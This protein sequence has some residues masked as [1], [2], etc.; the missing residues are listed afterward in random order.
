MPVAPVLGRW[1]P[2][3]DKFETSLVYRITSRPDWTSD[4]NVS[5]NKTRGQ[6]IT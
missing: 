3:A 2:E 6:D 5:N 4:E 1:R